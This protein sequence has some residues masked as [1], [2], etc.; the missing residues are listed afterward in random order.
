MG[1]QPVGWL[2][3]AQPATIERVSQGR[4]FFS[5]A[6]VGGHA[7]AAVWALVAFL[8]SPEIFSLRIAADF[9]RLE[10]RQMSFLAAFWASWPPSTSYGAASHDI[11]CPVVG[12]SG[13]RGSHIGL[14]LGRLANFINGEL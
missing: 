9:C 13:W 8:S 11:N 6:I 1:V 10:W 3:P 14:F 12:G 7:S 2:R 4:R 5:W